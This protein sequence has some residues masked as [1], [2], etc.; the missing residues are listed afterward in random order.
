MADKDQPD[1]LELRRADLERALAKKRPA[2]HDGGEGKTKG[3]MAGVGQALRLSSEFVAGVA[4]GA[5]LGW[6]IDHFAGTSPWGL[7]IFLL[8]GF[9]AGVLNVLRASGQIAEFG[10]GT[11]KGDRDPGKK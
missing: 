5:A 2:K 4:V 9:G 3:D 7:I 6:V 11:P 10:A 8:L 1:D